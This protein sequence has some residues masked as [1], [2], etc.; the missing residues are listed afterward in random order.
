MRISTCVATNTDWNCAKAWETGLVITTNTGPIRRWATP[1]PLRC[2]TPRNH[3]EPNQPVEL[4][5]RP[6]AV[7]KK[8]TQETGGRKRCW[9]SFLL[10]KYLGEQSNDSQPNRSLAPESYSLFSP[11]SGLKMGTSSSNECQSAE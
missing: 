4:E 7:V 2:I 8:I 6:P 1:P 10:S 3:T 5:V 9:T 11:L